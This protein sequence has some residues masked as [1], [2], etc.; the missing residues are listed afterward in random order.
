MVGA[1]L[2]AVDGR[3]FFSTGNISAILTGTS[4]LGFVAIGQTLVILGG[5]LDLSVPYVI[6]LT[7]SGRRHDGR[8]TGN[9]VPACWPPSGSPPGSGWPTA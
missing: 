3:N 9:I 4:I 1:V 2:T 8:Q 6:S 7:A 5:S